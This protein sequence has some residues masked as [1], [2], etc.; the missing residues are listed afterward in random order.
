MLDIPRLAMHTGASVR[1][2]RKKIDK[3]N[4]FL[5]FDI[6]TEDIDTSITTHSQDE[7]IANSK[8]NFNNAR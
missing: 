2:Y 8:I 5:R 1:V 4:V 3:P 7:L 6:C